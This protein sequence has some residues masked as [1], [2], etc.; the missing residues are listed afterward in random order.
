MSRKRVLLAGCA[1]L[2]LMAGTL[3]QTTPDLVWNRT[4]SVPVGL[5][6]VDRNA[7]IETGQLVAY[8][9][10]ATEAD[11]IEN[12]GYTGRGW[13]LLKRVAGLETDTV[14]RC[15]QLVLVNDFPAA[16]ALETDRSGRR[17]PVWAGCR[18]LAPG[19]VFL[20]ADHP[21]SLDG[22]YLGI[23]ARANI[24]GVAKPVWTWGPEDPPEAK[25]TTEDQM[26]RR[27]RLRGCHPGRARALSAHPFSCDRGSA[28][29]VPEITAGSPSDD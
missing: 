10:T 13:P 29:G 1:S 24:L 5:Y 15:G 9:P 14:C 23:A 27:A 26:A 2:F 4:T 6:F 20:L 19:E 7:R 28:K 12:R 3:L 11:W 16:H 22:R 17:L 21:Q 8:R 25:R 18:T